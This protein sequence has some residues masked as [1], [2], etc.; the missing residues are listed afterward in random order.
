MG[1]NVSRAACTSKINKI[2][3]VFDRRISSPNNLLKLTVL[4]GH[5]SDISPMLLAMNFSS[6]AC[7]EELY[8]FGKTNAL[9]C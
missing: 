5:D 6:S 3:T 1:R 8:R 7:I 2:L 4:S 9:N